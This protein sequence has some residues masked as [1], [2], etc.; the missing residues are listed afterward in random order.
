MGH[1]P[2]R[3]S[4]TDDAASMRAARRLDRLRALELRAER[5]LA[6]AQVIQVRRDAPSTPVLQSLCA[7]CHSRKT[8]RENRDAL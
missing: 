7:S 5:T 4:A 1:F 8:M 2:L 3:W 6:A